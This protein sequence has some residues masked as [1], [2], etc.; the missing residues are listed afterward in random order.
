MKSIL[1]FTYVTLSFSYQWF[2]NNKNL[3][4]NDKIAQLK[5]IN[6]YGFE[7]G[8]KCL[9]GLWENPFSYYLENLS[10]NKFNAL[11]I[12][13]SSEMILYN[14]LIPNP[15]LTIAEPLAMNLTSMQI[16]DLLF[17]KALE[18]NIVILLDI[19]RLKYQISNP[20]WYIVGDNNYSEDTLILAIDTLVNRYKDYPN[21][22]GVDLFN[23]PHYMA[24]YGSNNYLTDFRLFIEKCTF[25]I[26]PKYPDHS[27]L[28]FVNGIDWGKNLSQY[29]Y[30]PPNVPYEYLERIIVSPHIYGP[31]ITFIPSYDQNYLYQLW[32]NLF[33]YMKY[34]NRFH[35]CV[36]EWGGRFNHEKE[37]LWLD[38]FSQYLID[39]NFLNNFFW[40]LNPFSKD[41]S[42]L[43]SNWTTFNQQKLE[44]LDRVQKYPSY[45]W[46]QDKEIFIL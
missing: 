24:D 7:T 22:L 23:E 45:F 36:G 35:I 25:A 10:E 13:I 5:G 9:E 30:N 19:H 26:F 17:L 41:V 27:F 1:F 34:D 38:I 33:G 42:G 29:G 37:K 20:L 16:L 4:L 8:I 32:D 39:N 6:W 28:F 43:M 40:A 15:N 21:F 31:S 44:F 14:D 3:Y 12:P 11:R 18:K 2:V 46:V